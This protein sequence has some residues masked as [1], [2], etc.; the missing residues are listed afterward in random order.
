MRKLLYTLSLVMI[1]LESMGAAAVDLTKQK[2]AA[3]D[4]SPKAYSKKVPALAPI[5]SE[6]SEDFIPLINIPPKEGED[7]VGLEE[8]PIGVKRLTAEELA[9]A[10]A[11]P[12]PRSKA[13]AAA[14]KEAPSSKASSAAATGTLHETFPKDPILERPAH[15]SSSTHCTMPDEEEH[16]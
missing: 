8:E 10:A 4:S 13:S 9:A 15:C 12:Y 16:F 5:S 14:A 2:R 11:K 7:A 1:S 3:S 6:E